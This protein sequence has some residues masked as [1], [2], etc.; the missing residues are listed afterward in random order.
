MPIVDSNDM[1]IDD[2]TACFVTRVEYCR[3]K[4]MIAMANQLAELG[5]FEEIIKILGN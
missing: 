2:P 1:V 4:V 3:N 5:A